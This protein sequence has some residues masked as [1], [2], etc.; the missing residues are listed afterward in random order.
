MIFLKSCFLSSFIKYIKSF[1]NSSSND[2]IA[3]LN[4]LVKFLHLLLIKYLKSSTV[5]FEMVNGISLICIEF[6]ILEISPLSSGFPWTKLLPW[7]LEYL[8]IIVFISINV[9]LSL[10][11]AS[12]IALFISS[13]FSPSSTVITFHPIATKRIETF[14][15]NESEVA[16]SKDVL[17]ES[18]KTINLLSF[19]VPARLAASYEMP[20]IKSPSPHN[21]YVLKSIILFLPLLNLASRFASA[22]AIPTALANPCPNGPV[23]ISTPGVVLYSGCPGVIESICLNLCKSSKLIS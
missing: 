11:L 13:M 12:S 14:S 22:I 6:F 2:S 21:T 1:C 23:D 8:P 18:Y 4:L 5:V 16:P 19:K 7:Y 15:V 9:G 3:L 17:F 10:F 20:S